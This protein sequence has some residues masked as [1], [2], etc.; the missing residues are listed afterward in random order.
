MA[1]PTSVR[2]VRLCSGFVQ[3]VDSP[4]GDGAWIVSAFVWPQF[5]AALESNEPRVF[6]PLTADKLGLFAPQVGCSRL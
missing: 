4:G 3:I 6:K 5:A 1:V 2:T